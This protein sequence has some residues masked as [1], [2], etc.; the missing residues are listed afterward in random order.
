MTSLSPSPLTKG[1]LADITSTPLGRPM[2]G[3][4]TPLTQYMPWIRGHLTQGRSVTTYDARDFPIPDGTLRW[5]RESGLFGAEELE[6]LEA[7]GIPLLAGVWSGHQGPD[8]IDV[9]LRPMTWISAIDDKIIEMGRAD[10]AY[11]QACPHATALNLRIF[12]LLWVDS[13]R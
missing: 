6:R 12:R 1:N 7:Y 4:T 3:I 10:D 2:T 9:F 13:T 8:L 5:I 11:L